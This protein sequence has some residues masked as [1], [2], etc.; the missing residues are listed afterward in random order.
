M[1]PHE[2]ETVGRQI[3]GECGLTFDGRVGGGA[4]KETFRAI[5]GDGRD[6]ALK[7]Y[8]PGFPAERC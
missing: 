2:I 3:C 4:F 8:R 7:I 6:C 1:T 5:D